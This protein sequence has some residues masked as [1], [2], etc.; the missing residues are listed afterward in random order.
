MVVWCWPAAAGLDTEAGVVLGVVLEG[1][2]ELVSEDA[3]SVAEDE[4]E[5][6]R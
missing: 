1:A 5:V 2:R 6:E 4:A 3:R